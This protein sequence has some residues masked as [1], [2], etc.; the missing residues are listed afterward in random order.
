MDASKRLITYFTTATILNWYPLLEKD[1]FIG[2][3]CIDFAVKN[4]R[5]NIFAFVII[6]DLLV[7]TRT[8][9]N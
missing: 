8:K 6:N 2:G 1:L 5:A 9:A 3:Q 4:K 7:I